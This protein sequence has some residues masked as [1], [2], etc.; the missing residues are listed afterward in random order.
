M[1]PRE[2]LREFLDT[3]MF[4]VGDGALTI[5]TVLLVIAILVLTFWTAGAVRRATER[6]LRRRMASDPQAVNVYSW[7]MGAAVAALGV[8]IALR[9]TGM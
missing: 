8:L 7:L 6:L 4:Q 9:T 1:N 2:E 3:P 5:G